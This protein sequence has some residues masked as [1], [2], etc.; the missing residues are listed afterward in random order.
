MLSYWEH[1]SWLEKV[2]F[3]VVGSGIVGIN[4]A[5]ALRKNFPKAKIII[6]ER[7]ILPQGA[8]TKN[9]GFACFGSMSEILD[10]FKSH[11]EEEIINLIQKRRTGVQQL[12]RLLGEDK[13]QYKSFGGY[14]VFSEKET[15]L[16]D[17]CLSAR[18]AVNKML[19]PIFKQAVFKE[20]PNTFGF[21]N[22]KETLLWNRFEGQLDTGEMMQGLLDLAHRQGI[23]IVNSTS[24]TSFEENGDYVI[25]ETDQFSMKSRHLMIATNGFAKEILDEEVLPARAQ[26]LITKPIKDLRIKGTFHMYKGFNYFRNVDSRL[27]L[28]GGRHLNTNGEQTTAFGNTEEIKTYL[29]SLLKDVILPETAFEIDQWWSGIMGVG[30]KKRPIVKAVSARVYCGVRLGG[31]G[32]AIGSAVGQD[33]A[34]LVS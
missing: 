2:D 3:T 7:G 32:V 20:L 26:V 10:D 16:Y 11:S 4:C 1:K 22:V 33:L 21:R 31:M 14:E 19:L 18:D 13:L 8:S 25:I 17:E 34:D 5:L 30:H 24:V 28:G 12:K 6:L 23:L 29:T 15:E 27:L 9:A